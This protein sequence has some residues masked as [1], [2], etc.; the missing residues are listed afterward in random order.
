MSPKARPGVLTGEKGNIV[1]THLRILTTAIIFACTVLMLGQT[2]T[3]TST[4]SS[5][6]EADSLAV[7]AK[8]M[9]TLKGLPPEVGMVLKLDPTL[10]G[11][12]DYLASY[13][14]LAAFVNEHSQVAHNPR[15]YL[16]N[17][18]VHTDFVPEP[19]N[20]RIWDRT[21]ETMSLI[22][23]FLVAAGALLWIVKTLV[24]GRRWS[25]TSRAQ[26]DTMSKLLDR[27][28]S[29]DELLAY[30]ESPAG[31]RVLN[32]AGDST[33]PATRALSAPMSRIF[34]AVQVGVV[35]SAVGIGLQVV[36]LRVPPEVDAPVFA[37]SII[38]LSIGVGFILSALVSYV[39]SRRLGL[40]PPQGAA[41]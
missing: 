35:A 31:K 2:T 12:R 20:V 1:M 17:V 30:L 37:I 21:M 10:F 26:N 23:L 8:L 29:N 25:Q 27:F 15:F 33:E 16:E 32:V 22:F 13:P 9:S 4:T 18:E 41:S 24:E 5:A 36:S 6:L 19:P 3:T 11:N 34:W 28:S 7:R 14:S 38:L 40:W 39:L